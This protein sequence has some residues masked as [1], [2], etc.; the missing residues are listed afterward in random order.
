M[1]PT[2]ASFEAEPKPSQFQNFPFQTVQFQNQMLVTNNPMRP[3][4]YPTAEVISTWQNSNGNGVKRIKC[5]LQNEGS[6][7]ASVVEDEQC[8]GSTGVGNMEMGFVSQFPLQ[9]LDGFGMEMANGGENQGQES[10][11]AIGVTTPAEKRFRRMIKNRESAARSR[12]RKQAYTTQLELEV[13]QLKMENARLK[14]IKKVLDDIAAA[15]HA[16]FRM[17]HRR[18]FSSTF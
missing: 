3:Q 6:N 1:Y 14:K 10:E 17:M 8:E 11:D 15:D 5:D 18:T 9:L 2:S 13:Q 12:A 16:Q 7:K 4:S